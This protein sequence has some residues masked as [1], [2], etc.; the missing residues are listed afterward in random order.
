MQSLPDKFWDVLFRIS[1][2]CRELPKNGARRNSGEISRNSGV[3]SRKSGVIVWTESSAGFDFEKL[4]QLRVFDRNH[5]FCY[6]IGGGG[7]EA[8]FKETWRATRFV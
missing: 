6:F 2:F 7:P 8:S 3:I 1:M 4:F 5:E